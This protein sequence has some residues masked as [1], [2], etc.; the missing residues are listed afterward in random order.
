LGEGEM[1]GVTGRF[2]Q[3]GGFSPT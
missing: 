3:V 1:S 2:A